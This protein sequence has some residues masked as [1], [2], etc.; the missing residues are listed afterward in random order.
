MPPLVRTVPLM[1]MLPVSVFDWIADFL[2]VT[3][4]MDE[5]TGREG[6]PAD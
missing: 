5:F 4:S 3:R 1:R 2:G 6:T